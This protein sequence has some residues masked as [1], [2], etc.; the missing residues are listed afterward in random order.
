MDPGGGKAGRGRKQIV[1]APFKTL[2]A[3]LVLSAALSA[4]NT[5]TY[6]PPRLLSGDASGLPPANVVGGG[7]VLI[8]GTVDKRGAFTGPVILRSTPP[9]TNLV[10]DA[11]GGWKFSPA[12]GMTPDSGVAVV[13]A[14]VL[15]A[16]VYRPPTLNGPTLGEVPRD[17]GT[18]TADAPYAVS[19]ASPSY[20]PTAVS[21]AVVLFAVS[22]DEAGHITGAT[23]VGPSSGFDAAARD[24]LIQWKFRGGSYRGR[25]VPS[26]AYV[27]FGFSSPIVGG[28]P[29]SQ[30]PK[31]GK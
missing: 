26:T 31:P 5:L 18:P 20:P 30:P 6:T 9:Y 2:A 14:A 3:T 23:T 19:T 16:A 25:P 17:I 27:M 8:Q 10:L 22:L 7:E 24:A 29:G 15:I 21:G 28:T 11:I 4:Q 13:D 1:V 12:R